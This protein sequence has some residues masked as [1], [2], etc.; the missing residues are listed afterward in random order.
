MYNREQRE[1]WIKA[2]YAKHQFVPKPTSNALNEE[3]FAH[4][5]VDS[6][7]LATVLRLVGQGSSIFSKNRHPSPHFRQG[8][9]YI[10]ALFI[11][12]DIN[13]ANPLEKNMT[14]LMQAVLAD[15]LLFVE[16]LMHNGADLNQCVISLF[17]LS[18]GVLKPNMVYF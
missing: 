18:V 2:K 4:V 15:S 11:G 12:A 17:S 8:A 3:L 10:N 1:T 5:S 14:P 9:N 16:F 13:W 7:D 6:D